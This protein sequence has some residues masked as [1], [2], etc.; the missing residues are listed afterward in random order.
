MLRE[1]YPSVAL[2][3]RECCFR[4]WLG[5]VC[6]LRD[7][8][9][10]RP[11]LFSTMPQQLGVDQA[12]ARIGNSVWVMWVSGLV[13]STS[14]SPC[15]LS[16]CTGASS[17]NRALG[18]ACRPAS[19][20]CRVQQLCQASSQSKPFICQSRRS[21]VSWNLGSAECRS[22]NLPALGTQNCQFQD[23][24]P[25]GSGM[26]VTYTGTSV[27]VGSAQLPD[28]ELHAFILKEQKKWACHVLEWML[29]SQTS[30]LLV[31]VR[32]SFFWY[33]LLS[34]NTAR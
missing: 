7:K 32:W 21:S 13:P 24:L 25:S 14:V 4:T 6:I 17:W 26:C 2:V 12:Q 1:S 15:C 16:T 23:I 5:F 27:L 22:V 18:R 30:F 10:V 11:L 28:L 34:V 31:P 9:S 20:G 8:S 29:C 3:E 33:W 19:M